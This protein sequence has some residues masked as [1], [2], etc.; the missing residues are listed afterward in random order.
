MKRF[1]SPLLLSGLSLSLN[2]ALTIQ[3]IRTASNNVL[4]V[5]LKSSILN[6]NEVSA[7]ASSWS[8]NDEAPLAIN[9]YAM[10]ADQCDHHVYLTTAAL[11]EGISYVIKTPYGDTTVQFSDHTIFCESIKT[12]QVAYSALCKTNFANLAIWLGDGGQKKIE[13][14]L[15][16]YEVFEQYTGKVVADGT[17]KEVG[18]NTTSGD[19]VYRIDLSEVPEGGPYKIA[20]K[21]Y[22]CSHPFGIGGPF[23]RRLAY[24][25]FRGQYY[26]R[27]GCPIQ[28]PYGLDI[29]GKPCHT[30]VYQVNGTP[31]EAN[32]SVSGSEPSFACYGGYHD[33]GDAD[34]RMFHMSNPVINLMVYE[35]FPDLFFDGQFNIP[36]KFD[37]EYNIIGKGNGIPD[38]I[39]EA[40]WGTLVWEYLQN[41]DGSIQ[42]GTETKGY[43]EPFDAPLD[44]DNK[45]YGTLKP[46]DKAAAIGAGLFMHLARIIRPY[47]TTRSDKLAGRA[48]KSYAFIGSR[49]K[50]PE[51]LYY[52]IQK[53]LFDG[54]E[55]AHEKVKSLK[56]AVDNYKENLFGCNGYSINNDKFDN[57]GY[58]LS[59]LVEKK[60]P[61][62]AAVADYFKAALKAA[63]DVNM[64]ELPKYAYPVGNN[65][66]GTSWGH[67]VM[68]PLYACAPLLHW[69]FTDV[70]KYFDGACDMMNYQLGL[71]PLG[72]C[73]VTGLGFH[74]VHNPHDRES[75]YTAGK[76]WGPKPGITVFGPGI[77]SSYGSAD[78]ETFPA[79]TALPTERKFGDDMASICTAEFTIFET[80]SHYALYT[81]L[82][83][84]GTW[85]EKDDPFATQQVAAE[86][87]D[88]SA[89]CHR[90]VPAITLYLRNRVLTIAFASNAPR[91]L[92]GALFLLN[93][94]RL[95]GFTA[96]M[97]DGRE[98]AVS[99]AVDGASLRS[100]AG[101]VLLCRLTMDGSTIFVRRVL[102]GM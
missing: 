22:G 91:R 14:T 99:V 29:R 45:K 96:A 70:Q 36:D 43:P 30:T 27:C 86:S 83:N 16:A 9:R 81:V 54:D 95:L 46:D 67:N 26:Q 69:R 4:I 19:F 63:A 7:T 5:V 33:A 31:G 48:Q 90:K 44:Q 1:I 68:Q 101:A 25:I 37:D 17:L 76:G 51:D 3:E 59:Y 42:Y 21:G 78:L 97:S 28:A 2:A 34:R 6:V 75:A 102:S 58:F 72:I 92:S 53:Y 80:M 23:S 65:P 60:R 82:S 89:A 74:Q 35:A 49:I 94:K 39:D 50:K 12:N 62:D 20:V 77:V 66:V 10:V 79:I 73:F 88:P 24:T 15:P 100:I 40:A 18:G 93:G 47:D 55:A 41:D 57:P 98:K 85:D 13:G 52:N 8:I 32:L 87:A 56:N 11:E 84:G 61:T 71:N 64:A 38:I